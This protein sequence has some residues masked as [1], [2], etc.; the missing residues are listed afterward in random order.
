MPQA[1]SQRPLTTDARI[2]SQVNPCEI[3]GGQ[4]D[5]RTGFSPCTSTNAP[6]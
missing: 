2:R 1:V 3:C 4:S 6:H 5:T